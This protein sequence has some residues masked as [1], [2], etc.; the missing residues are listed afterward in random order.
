MS[1]EKLF[2]EALIAI[3][4]MWLNS[5]EQALFLNNHCELVTW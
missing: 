4:V 1:C 2:I 3:H 5:L